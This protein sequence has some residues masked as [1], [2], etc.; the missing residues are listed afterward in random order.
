MTFRT[1]AHLRPHVGAAIDVGSNS[2]HLLVGVIG[3]AGVQPLADESALLGLGRIVDRE[4]HLPPDTRAALVETVRA[5]AAVAGRSGAQHLTLLGTEPLRRASD[6]PAVQAEIL[7][8]VGSP[9]VLLSPEQEA[10]LTLLGVTA[11]DPPD[12]TLLVVDIGGGS[13]E[14]ILASAG[15]DVLIGTL[16]T[17]SAR[18]TA[19]FVEHDPPTWSE[20]GALRVAA[21][22]LV[23]SLPPGD[24]AR[25]I[26]VGGT[27]SNLAKLMP[28]GP[29]R[30]ELASLGEVW[31]SLSVSPADGLVA[32][33]AVNRRRAGMLAAGAALVEALMMR[34]GLS[35]V[36]VSQASLREGALL[37][38][39]LAGDEWL[40]R[41]SELCAPASASAA[42]RGA[43]AGAFEPVP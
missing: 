11:G 12:A 40:E 13:S 6:R 17:G 24:P 3:P 29:Q 18:L 33:F 30:I 22:R 31:R 36:E 28:G 21:R 37:A 14:T 8:A 9:L 25:C 26:M 27:A 5:Y 41:S 39:A 7:R 43:S 2:V 20:I 35:M 4:G 32:A 16:A 42:V 15:G 34:Y 19:E 38:R 1:L 10:Y 23:A